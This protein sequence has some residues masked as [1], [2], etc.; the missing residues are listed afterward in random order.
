MGASSVAVA[1]DIIH[2]SVG[3]LGILR[4]IHDKTGTARFCHR[5]QLG[6]TKLMRLSTNETVRCTYTRLWPACSDV[7]AIFQ[8]ASTSSHRPAAQDNGAEG[9]CRPFYSDSSELSCGK[10]ASSTAATKPAIEHIKDFVCEWLHRDGA[11][12]ARGLESKP[13]PWDNRDVSQFHLEALADTMSALDDKLQGAIV[14]GNE[15]L[16]SPLS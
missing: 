13:G 2:L 10:E 7:A 5:D 9:S 12:E 1:Q 14:A 3:N 6:T 16:V 11:F 15:L 8:V 4:Q